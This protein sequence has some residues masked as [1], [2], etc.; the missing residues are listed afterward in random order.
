ML[1]I[2]TSRKFSFS[3]TI[4][5]IGSARSA[6]LWSRRFRGATISLVDASISFAMFVG[7]PGQLSIMAIMMRTGGCWLCLILG[8]DNQLSTTMEGVVM[9][10]VVRIAVMVASAIVVEITVSE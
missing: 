6:K 7:R 2:V 9:M 3:R 10:A 5:T 4:C 8:G 1:E